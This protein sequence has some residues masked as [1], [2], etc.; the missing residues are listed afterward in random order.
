[1]TMFYKWYFY[2]KSIYFL[3]RRRLKPLLVRIQAGDLIANVIDK[4][5][6]SMNTGKAWWTEFGSI[7]WET[8]TD[9]QNDQGRL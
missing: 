3:I 9:K 1:M 6:K 8:V 5:T 4:R 2:L 7:C